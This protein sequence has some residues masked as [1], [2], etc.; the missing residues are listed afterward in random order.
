MCVPD[1]VCN[2]GVTLH[3]SCSAW[4]VRSVSSSASVGTH[5]L[6]LTHTSGPARPPEP[7]LPSPSPARGPSLRALPSV[8]IRGGTS[9][10][11]RAPRRAAEERTGCLPQGCTV[12]VLFPRSH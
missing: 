2:P 11:L 10:A 1:R 4:Q 7:A 6:F 12:P 8:L 5:G 3:N 9:R